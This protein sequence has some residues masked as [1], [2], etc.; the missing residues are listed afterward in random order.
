[1]AVIDLKRDIYI[2][3]SIIIY[4][5]RVLRELPCVKAAGERYPE[6]EQ[7]QPVSSVEHRL[8]GPKG[9]PDSLTNLCVITDLS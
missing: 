9:E 4:I 2:Q 5:N 3:L 6:R 8:R 1:M 7:L